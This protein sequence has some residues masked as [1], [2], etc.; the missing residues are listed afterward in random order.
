MQEPREKKRSRRILKIRYQTGYGPGRRPAKSQ[1]ACRLG[2]TKRMYQ[3]LGFLSTMTA[4][5]PDDCR[6]VFRRLF[7][8]DCA[9]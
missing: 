3:E 6:K 2:R 7:T 9:R 8:A 5:G 1:N 4:P